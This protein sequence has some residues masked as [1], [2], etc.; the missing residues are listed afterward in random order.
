M[1][2]FSIILVITLILAA[3]LCGC[4]NSTNDPVSDDSTSTPVT[5]EI[6][7]SIFPEVETSS[8]DGLDLYRKEVSS[9]L[10][11]LKED[12]SFITD[13]EWEAISNDWGGDLYRHD[14]FFTSFD[15]LYEETSKYYYPVVFRDGDALILWYTTE[16]GSVLLEE[17]YGYWNDSNYVGKLHSDSEEEEWIYS[18]PDAALTY[19]E[20]TGIVTVWQ[21][22]ESI[23]E[24]TGIPQGSIYCG[25]SNF[26]G[27]IFR[28]G[29]DVYCIN[30]EKVYNEET[31]TLEEVVYTACIAHNVKYVID[32]DYRAS[33][34]PWSQPLFIMTDGSVK[35]YVSWEGDADAPADDAS[36]L[37]PPYHEGGIG[38]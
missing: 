7:L 34:D 15:S 24:Y 16:S 18:K 3:A 8:E 26:E 23:D 2:K 36:H 32:A 29:T 6:N 14:S 38:V 20:K 19:S 1:K 35:V 4:G 10:E 21:F 5:E 12:E 28:S 17:V 11:S 33:S 9:R 30:T 22:G 31:E 25:Y 13:E 27:Y 37:V